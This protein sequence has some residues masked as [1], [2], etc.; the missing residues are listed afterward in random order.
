[1]TPPANAPTLTGPTTRQRSARAFPTAHGTIPTGGASQ[2]IGPVNTCGKSPR[3]GLHITPRKAGSP[4][5]APP[6]GGSPGGTPQKS[7]SPREGGTPQKS[8]FPQEGGSSPSLAGTS[9]ILLT[10]PTQVL[11]PSLHSTVISDFADAHLA[12]NPTAM[13]IQV[14][15][16]AHAATF[17][18]E[19]TTDS[20]LAAIFLKK[21][22]EINNRLDGMQTTIAAVRDKFTPWLAILDERITTT[23]KRIKATAS[24]TATMLCGEFAQKFSKLSERIGTTDDTL[25]ATM[26]TMAAPGLSELEACIR[27]LESRPSVDLAPNPPLPH[28]NPTGI[29]I[30][31]AQPHS[32]PPAARPCVDTTFSPRFWRISV[33]MPRYYSDHRALV[34][35]IY[36]E[37]GGI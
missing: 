12:D 28:T 30:P 7:G 26:D 14:E 16:E 33:R 8:G 27:I 9:P 32:N 18:Q 36:A 21:F 23:N 10:D 1:M 2:W 17:D 4:A 35:V 31:L 15:F 24:S 29:V 11:G 34:A 6:T 19:F 25:K 3:R 20:S 5:G 37:G 22:D 13:H